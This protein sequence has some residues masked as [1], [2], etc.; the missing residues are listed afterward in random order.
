MSPAATEPRAFRM[1]L[2]STAVTVLLWV[3]VLFHIAVPVIVLFD[4]TS[5]IRKLV[6]IV[7]V[8]SV[9]LLGPVYCLLFRHEWNEPSSPTQDSEDHDP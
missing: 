8:S 4:R 6:W 7:V 3:V 1:R 9:P 2:D 5:W